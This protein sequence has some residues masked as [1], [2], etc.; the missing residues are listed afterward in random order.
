MD[1][2]SRQQRE[3]EYY[4]QFVGMN[5]INEPVD[6]APIS[7][8]ERRP[9]N[10]YW[11]V[12]HRVSDL[13]RQGGARILDVGC[14]PGED[15]VRYSHLGFC[16]YG[17]DISEKNIAHAKALCKAHDE[18]KEPHLSVQVAENLE[19]QSDFF[20]VVVGIDILHHIDIPQTIKEVLRVLKPGGHALF[21]EP[22]RS[23]LFDPFRNTKIVKHFCRNE[24]SF[25]KHITEDER[26]LDASDLDSI[27]RLVHNYSEIRFNALTRISLI[28]GESHA[29]L[30]DWIEKL[31]FYWV[32]FAPIL[33]PQLAG[34]AVIEFEKAYSSS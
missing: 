30:R 26:K 24:K 18:E 12:Y 11:H 23:P 5:P 10:P 20:D 13:R 14:G 1:C 17:V 31:G 9:W 22:I 6:L 27:R 2:S 34:S 33:G 32:Q 28:L 8:V 29:T 19:C 4:D 25:K 16:V 7:G 15:I 21:R 3:R